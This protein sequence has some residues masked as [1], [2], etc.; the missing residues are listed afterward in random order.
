MTA[1]ERYLVELLVDFVNT[2]DPFGTPTDALATPQDLAAFLADHGIPA[3]GISAKDVAETRALRERLRV[4]FTA[5]QAESAGLAGE[6]LAQAVVTLGVGAAA[7]EAACIT[8]NVVGGS[9]ASRIGALA[10]AGLIFA[11][12]EYGAERL[13]Q[14]AAA[15]CV[16]VFIDQS[17]N[18]SRRFC[19]D[20]CSNRHNVAQYRERQRMDG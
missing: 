20:T 16:D 5:P 4:A 13:K 6:L 11:G 7:D 15:P 10:S 8:F 17:K 19:G 14:C 9:V 18:K 3:D 1:Y 12:R 2:V